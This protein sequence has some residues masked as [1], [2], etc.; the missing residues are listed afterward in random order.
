MNL[1]RVV[2]SSKSVDLISSH[3]PLSRYK[4][5]HGHRGRTQTE[6][7]TRCATSFP[8]KR[9]RTLTNIE[10]RFEFLDQVPLIIANVT[11]VELLQCVDASSADGTVQCVLLFQ[12]APV[13][14]LIAAFDLDRN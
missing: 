14:W 5:C 12:M 11:A 10:D 1:E 6:R 8:A 2:W 9:K 3:M 7:Q 13:H 4:C